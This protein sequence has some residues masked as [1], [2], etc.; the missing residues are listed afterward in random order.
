MSAI[1]RQIWCNSE[2]VMKMQAS[3]PFGE[4]N[5]ELSL[6]QKKEP[7]AVMV[8]EDELGKLEQFVERLIDNYNELKT[9]NSSLK[10]RLDKIEQRNAQ[11]Q[12]LVNTLQNDRTVMH[13]RVTGMISRIEDWEK[14][15]DLADDATSLADD[16]TTGNKNAADSDQ[17]FSLAAE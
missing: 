12:E 1:Q 8:H 14:S 7:A 15:L 10:E 13:D 5:D 17:T 3:L 11:N 9:E 4:R 6:V 16:G 2:T